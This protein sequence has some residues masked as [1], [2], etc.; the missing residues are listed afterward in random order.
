MKTTKTT[1]MGIFFCG[2]QMMLADARP[3]ED[4]Y[5]R[6]IDAELVSHTG[7]SAKTVKINKGGK[8]MEAPI[9]NFCAKDQKFIRDWMGKTPATIAYA[10]R[11]ES[12]KRVVDSARGKAYLE[13]NKSAVT[14]YDIKVTNL[15]R[16][17]VKGV[18]VEYKAFMRNNGDIDYLSSSRR[19]KIQSVTDSIKIPSELAFNRSAKITTKSLRIDS[20]RSS[21][22]SYN[23][24]DELL[25]VIVRVYDPE[26]RI[27]TEW[28]TP[29]R[30]FEKMPWSAG[31]GKSST[32]APRVI[33]E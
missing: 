21:F 8:E 33:V 7:A 6:T 20:S 13:K 15:T 1:L 3:F 17:T 25:G 2:M 18:R 27:I 9:A 31:D 30:S 14:V 5:G 12:D 11:V 16:Q 23:F 24:S 4:K 22:S 32:A 29:N 19:G 26:D 10:F 28:R